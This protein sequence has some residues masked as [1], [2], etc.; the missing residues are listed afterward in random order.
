MLFGSR[1]V[2]FLHDEYFVETD[3]NDRAHDVA[4]ALSETMARGANEYLPDVPILP[5]RVKPTLMRQWA[6]DA[7]QVFVN[8]RLVPWTA[9]AA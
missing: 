7:E 5:S 2:L 4:Y 9:D 1:T 3:D 8:G 6:K